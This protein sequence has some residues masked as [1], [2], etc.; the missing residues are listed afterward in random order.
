LKINIEA[1]TI[2]NRLKISVVANTDD[3]SKLTQNEFINLSEISGFE[4]IEVALDRLKENIIRNFSKP[5]TID[6]FSE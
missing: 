3:G 6:R 2:G 1:K 5:I 4:F